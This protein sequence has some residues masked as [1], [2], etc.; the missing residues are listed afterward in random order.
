MLVLYSSDARPRYVSDI[1][2]ALAVPAGARFQFRYQSRYLSPE[3]QRMLGENSLT[4]VTALVCFIGNR[5]K[6]TG[7]E[8]LLPVRLAKV[9]AV[10]KIG[11]AYVFNMQATEY[12]DLGRWP[13][14]GAEIVRHGAQVVS[15]IVANNHN[16]YYAVNWDSSGSLATKSISGNEGWSGVAERVLQLSTFSS[17]YLL[18]LELADSAGS[19]MQISA[20][21]SGWLEFDPRRSYR[22]RVWFYGNSVDFGN[23]TITLETDGE[24]L[25]SISDQKYV[26]R[27]RYDQADFWFTPKTADQS[28]RTLLRLVSSPADPSDSADIATEV[29]LRC[30]VVR[31]LAPRMWLALLAGASATA[32][33][34]PGLLGEALP[35]EWRLVVA[36]AGA[37]GVAVA[38]G[39]R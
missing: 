22:V 32:V 23:R 19:P 37:V 4:N 17:S 11:D 38:A 39:L 14:T 29:E 28:K 20:D 24:V 8:F 7:E 5:N 26:V 34:M 21:D 9:C 2:T 16:E 6:A 10:E 31:P 25:S 35:I 27:S 13:R 18:R 1:A 12:P 36:G 3:V 33:A 15:E 30:L